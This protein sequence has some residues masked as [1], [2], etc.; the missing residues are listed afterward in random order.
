MRAIKNLRSHEAPLSSQRNV[1]LNLDIPNHKN[2]FLPVK[3]NL[4]DRVHKNAS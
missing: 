1:C 2:L 3:Q 4:M